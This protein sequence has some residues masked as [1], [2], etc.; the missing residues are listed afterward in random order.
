MSK[1]VFENISKQYNKE[2]WAVRNVS[3]TADD[4]EFLVLVGP[5]GCGKTTILRMIAGLEEISEGSLSFD[6]KKM[7]NIPARERDV[8]MVFQNYALYPHLTVAQNIAFPLSVRKEKKAIINDRVDEVLQLLDLKEYGSKKPKELSGGQRQRV[9]LG[10]AIV[11]KPKV[12]LFDEPLSNLD[13]KLRVQ[14]RSEITNLHKKFGITSIYVTHDQV[15][16]M[17]M[18]SRLI[19]LKDGV[20]MQ[21]AKPS[22]LY[23]KPDNLFVAGFI[24]SPQ[25]N[26]FNGKIVDFV[27]E[28]VLFENRNDNLSLLIPKSNF[29]TNNLEKNTEITVGIRPES[30]ALANEN[31]INTIDVHIDNIEYIG[32]EHILYFKIGNELKAVRYFGDLEFSKKINLLL[33]FPKE[34]IIPYTKDG[35]RF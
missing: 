20:V 12:F 10:R 19:V 4:G 28:D 1:I 27:N 14:M 31:S 9:A 18:G 32:Y 23:E 5:S 35:N 33:Y 26:F 7:N 16:A 6:G 24:G 15:E 2:R 22:E 21:N 30:I 17:T 8:G 3:F 25:M 34:F 11:R 29:L 13:A